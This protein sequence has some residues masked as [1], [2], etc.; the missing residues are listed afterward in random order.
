MMSVATFRAVGGFPPGY[1]LYWEDVFFSWKAQFLGYHLGVVPEA[2]IW[3]SVGAA[4]GSSQSSTYYYWSTRN[5]FVFARDVGVSRWQLVAGIA[6][7]ETLRPFAR[8]LLRE[9]QGRFAK[10]EAAI[11]GTIAGFREAK[12]KSRGPAASHNH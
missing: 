10:A 3:H 7:I 8:A 12:K 11:R 6:G 2:R 5:R 9:K 1:F 4:S